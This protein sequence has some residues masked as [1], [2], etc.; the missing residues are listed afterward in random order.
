MFGDEWFGSANPGGKHH[1][2]KDGRWAYT[3]LLDAAGG[4]RECVRSRFVRRRSCLFVRRP[5]KG[6]PLRARHSNATTTASHRDHHRTARAATCVR[7]DHTL[8][9][10]SITNP[11][12]VLRSPWNTNPHAYL[13][14]A[15]SVFRYKGG[16]YTTFPGCNEFHSC[17]M[18][19]QL[20][21]INSCLNGYTHGPVHIMIGGQWNGQDGTTATISD[22]RSER[23]QLLIFKASAR[24]SW[25]PSSRGAPPPFPLP[26]FTAHRMA[27][28]GTVAIDSIGSDRP[29]HERPSSTG[30]HAAAEAAAAGG[31][32]D[33]RAAARGVYERERALRPKRGV[34]RCGRWWWALVVGGGGRRRAAPLSRWHVGTLAVAAVADVDV[35]RCR[36]LRSALVFRSALS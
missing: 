2:V 7:D 26:S 36:L 16:G 17:F 12:G 5:P 10:S 11:Y 21:E 23:I 1:V 8:R 4:A 25:D 14:R 28:S 9:Y 30:E 3:P 31:K 33:P 19:K 13:T 6:P 24:K 20:S 27:P 35:C 15:T 22:F 32:R 29:H 18:K 34:P